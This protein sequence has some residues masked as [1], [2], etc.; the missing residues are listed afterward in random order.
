MKPNVDQNLRK[1]LSFARAGDA[2]GAEKIYREI[3]AVFPANKRAQQ[4]LAELANPFA[5]RP[6]AEAVETLLSL[7]DQNRMS[8]ALDGAMAM[9]ALHPARADLY[10]LAGAI[11]G[12]LGR[13]D[14]ALASYGKAIALNPK[15]G[16]ALTNRCVALLRLDRLEEAAEAGDRAV[17]VAT[18][19]AGAHSNRAM[20]L[21]LLGRTRE[22]AAGYDRAMELDP[23]SAELHYNKANLL[24]DL[25]H[26]EDAITC[27]D[28]AI[29]LKPD[30]AAAY[31]NR[32]NAQ[33]RLGL[34]FEALASYDSAI[35]I[36]PGFAEAHSNRGIVLR[37][38]KRHD[39]ALESCDRAVELQPDSAAILYN[40]ATILQDLN[41]LEAAVSS[42]DR[43]LL[44][45]PD[46]VDAHG[47]RGGVLMTLHRYDEALAS[48][49]K[50][51]ALR[52][53]DATSHYNLGHI[54]QMLG[55]LDE[56]VDSYRTAVA[57]KPDHA[58]AYAHLL[59]QKARM[60]L[61]DEAEE[62]TALSILH[63][64]P[65][66]IPPFAMLAIEDDAERHLL[67]SKAWVRQKV[68]GPGL[69]FPR[70]RGDAERIRIGYFSAD[71]HNHATMHLMAKLLERHD[72]SRFEIHAFS[73]G[74]IKDGFSERAARA[75]DAF[76]DVSGL[77][78]R[79]IAQ[80]AKD[81]Q[82]DVAVDLKGHTQEARLGIFA[83]R[84][85]PVQ[86]AFLGYP[87]STGASFIDYLVAD[88]VVIPETHSH[89]YSEQIIR[90]PDSYQV[91]DDS[92]VVPASQSTRAD[93]DLPAEGVVFCSFNSSYKIR[94]AE[95][96]IWMEILHQVDG[97]VLWLLR[98][99]R[100]VEANLKREAAARGIAPERL[101]FSDKVPLPE[102]LA[103]HGCADIFL[104]SFNCNAHTTASDALWAGVPVITKL[105][106]SFAARVA[107][108]LL[109]ALDMPE[110]VTETE[111]D[112]ARL[113]IELAQQPDRLAAV[114]QKISQNRRTTPLFDTET[115]TRNIERAYALAH[116]R[117]L[118]GLRPAPLTIVDD[119]RHQRK[120]AA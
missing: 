91:N 59:H 37:D 114:K 1:A 36:H 116:Q 27:Y 35:A 76:H 77:D 110:L 103:R 50:V 90:L 54:L 47:N 82:I 19:S 2:A 71:F 56:A 41:R 7:Y 63:T 30:Y 117:H 61:W 72:G 42:Y 52:P 18:H 10:N 96:G 109:H 14:D 24:Q 20:V 45:D 100:W 60:A 62:R 53:D 15:D 28:A 29:R 118:D 119:A 69:S 8:E 106:Q 68:D 67:R 81:R 102:H 33:R 73:Y 104:D 34:L 113:A 85:A 84:P 4:G 49:S 88:S 43:A 94:P 80:L 3:L 51:A 9:L 6:Y 11:Q 5:G 70:K 13:W 44:L 21:K 98:D 39:E 79:A 64:A 66:A 12:A 65:D 108:S 25:N 40:H 22:A 112:Y 74:F 87:G 23:R 97:S 16:D 46:H 99:N 32:G 31:S 120:Y 83:H 17:K 107:G 55:R 86:I 78:D 93:H 101:A 26:L 111:A 89:F 115:F 57:L 92:R 95:F 48:L 75:V 58:E 38:M 105:G